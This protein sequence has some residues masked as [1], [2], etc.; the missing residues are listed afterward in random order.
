MFHGFKST[1]IYFHRINKVELSFVLHIFIGFQQMHKLWHGQNINFKLLKS[2][3]HDQTNVYIKPFIQWC[4]I[5]FHV[6]STLVFT[7]NRWQMY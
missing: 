1:I 3:L 2:V 6:F 7:W 5:Q 4:E